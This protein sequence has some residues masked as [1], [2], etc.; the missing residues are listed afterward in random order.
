MLTEGSMKKGGVNEKPIGSQ[1][2]DPPK[3]QSPVNE[4]TIAF[5]AVIKDGGYET[6]YITPKMFGELATTIQNKGSEILHFKDR[7][8]VVVGILMVGKDIG[9]RVIMY[10]DYD[11]SK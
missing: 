2:P 6:V 11:K 10:G 5:T 9:E 7:S 3:P 4:S 1:R 8:V